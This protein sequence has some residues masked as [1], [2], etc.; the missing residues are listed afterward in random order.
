ML[1]VKKICLK[2]LNEIYSFQNPELSSSG[3]TPYTSSGTARC[4][5]NGGGYFQKG[6]MV[7]VQLSLNIKT[8]LS[9]NNYWVILQNMPIPTGVQYAALA[10]SVRGQNGGA[11]S[12]YVN[13]SGNL[14]VETD[15]SALAVG[16][17]VEIA[18]WYIAQ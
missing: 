6:K 7:F 11:I 10:A 16:W 3:L 1:N 18:G 8:S 12:G 17:N 14:V 13:S 5:I 9:A 2:M 15:N 4:A